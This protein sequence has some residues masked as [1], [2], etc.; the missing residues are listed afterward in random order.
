MTT[1][2]KEPHSVFDQLLYTTYVSFV[3]SLGILIVI[4]LLFCL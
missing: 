1:S 4:G 2:K 3:S